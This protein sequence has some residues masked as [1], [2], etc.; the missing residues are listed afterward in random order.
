M[1]LRHWTVV[2]H[3]CSHVTMHCSALGH[4][5]SGL[6]SNLPAKMSLR[7]GCPWCSLYPLLL[8]ADCPP[9]L[10]RAAKAEFRRS[11]F[12]LVGT[13]LLTGTAHGA[14]VSG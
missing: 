10:V 5:P 2:Q 13:Q 11:P 1:N 9:Y 4:R 3:F 8:L 6:N 14:P 7:P 12:N